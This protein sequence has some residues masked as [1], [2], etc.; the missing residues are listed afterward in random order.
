MLTQL[1]LRPTTHAGEFGH[2]GESRFAALDDLGEFSGSQVCIAHGKGFHSPGTDAGDR[3]AAIGAPAVQTPSLPCKVTSGTEGGSA[4]CFGAE[5]RPPKHEQPICDASS[6]QVEIEQCLR[7]DYSD[8]PICAPAGN[9]PAW[10]ALAHAPPKAACWTSSRAEGRTPPL[11]L[12][13]M[14]VPGINCRPL[15][16]RCPSR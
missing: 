11:A 13:A 3:P 5:S 10:S 4:S 1:W 16:D 9:R 15:R 6:D 14:Q 8:R 12:A 7:K 2:A